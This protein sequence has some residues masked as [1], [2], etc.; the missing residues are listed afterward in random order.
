M[1]INPQLVVLKDAD[2]SS[3][4]L[5][6]ALSSVY[7]Q[8]Q[9]KVS[10][11]GGSTPTIT[12]AKIGAFQVAWPSLSEQRKIVDRV[13]REGS[14]ILATTS[15]ASHEIELLREFRTRLIADV[16]TGKIDVREA[17]ARLPEEVE[18]PD[19]PDETETEDDT[20]AV[21]TDDATEVPEE[22]DA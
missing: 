8:T 15:R 4:F 20:D 5:T 17:S 12:Q 10:V 9:V 1:T 18:E 2:G 19:L 16:V 14:R 22:A 3:E 11:I 13:K 7:V 6:L 21:D